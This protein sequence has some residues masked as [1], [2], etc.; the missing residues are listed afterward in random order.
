MTPKIMALQVGIWEY[1]YA[2]KMKYSQTSLRPAA[3]SLH[4]SLNSQKLLPL[5]QC[6][7]NLKTAR[8]VAVKTFF[9]SFIAQVGR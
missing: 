3:Y 4:G 8:R 5:T 6:W 2:V 9:P 1:N 7:S